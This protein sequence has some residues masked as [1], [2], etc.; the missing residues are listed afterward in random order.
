VITSVFIECSTCGRRQTIK[1]VGEPGGVT[2][3]EAV[4]CGWKKTSTAWFCPF[5]TGNPADLEKLKAAVRT[6]S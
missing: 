2:H 1:P 4:A 6:R 3:E 5:H